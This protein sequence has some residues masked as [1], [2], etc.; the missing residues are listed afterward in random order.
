MNST[1]RLP[2]GRKAALAEVID[3]RGQVTV[4]VLAEHF[5]VSIDTIRRDLDQLDSDG[6]IVRT[7]GGALSLTAVS[8]T[9][10]RGLD[11]R[12][13]VAAQE[14]ERIGELAASLVEDGSVIM[15]NAGTTA[16]ALTRALRNHRDLTIATNNLQVPAEIMPTAFRDLYVFGGSV[17]S[18]TQAT[19]G[20]VSFNLGPGGSEIDLRCDLALIAVGAVSEDGYSTSN[21]GDAAMMAEMMSR[22]EKVVVMADSSKFDRRLFAQVSA[23][24][25]ADVIVTDAPPSAELRRAIDEAGVELRFP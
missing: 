19:T 4:A 8:R 6:Q 10:D 12:L 9:I 1:R 2:A 22:A 17:R 11:V 20:P 16:L 18:I 13:R 3:Q 15:I 24:G 7:H 23:L 21:L 5:G 14:K 25:G